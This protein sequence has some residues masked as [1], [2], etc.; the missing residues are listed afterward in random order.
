MTTREFYHRSTK[1]DILKRKRKKIEK[2]HKT[3]EKYTLATQQN[4]NVEHKVADKKSK[5][6]SQLSSKH[7]AQLSGT[8]TTKPT[9]RLNLSY[10][11]H[12][13]IAIINL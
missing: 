3:L 2:G 13:T 12:L 10:L 11:D 4:L 6:S 1:G 7:T 8:N 9:Y 5:S